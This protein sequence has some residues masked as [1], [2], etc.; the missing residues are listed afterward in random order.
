M[1]PAPILGYPQ[2]RESPLQSGDT[3]F[4]SYSSLERET[5][6]ETQEGLPGLQ[7][8]ASPIRRTN[9]SLNKNEGGIFLNP[10]FCG[11]E[12]PMEFSGMQVSDLHFPKSEYYYDFSAT[13]IDGI[14]DDLFTRQ[15][16]DNLA[17]E[18]TWPQ[19]YGSRISMP[20][21]VGHDFSSEHLFNSPQEFSNYEMDNLHIL[22]HAT[23]NPTAHQQLRTHNSSTME[24]LPS[25]DSP[26]AFERTPALPDT[27]AS[28]ISDDGDGDSGDGNLSVN[29]ERIS[30]EPYAKL[31]YRALLAAPNHS[32]VLQEIY[33]W[34]IDHTDKANSTSSGWRNSIRHNL[35][36]NAVSNFP[37][38]KLQM[39]ISFRRFE[40]QIEKPT[41]KRP[42]ELQNGC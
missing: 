30:D 38:E 34:F 35:S 6:M 21:R 5:S 3:N 26:F 27:L 40:R 13:N 1:K 23:D 10:I 8:D 16:D 19:A 25:N 31:I 42:S 36:M 17:Y 2:F 14:Q 39:L 24:D 12:S 9:I 29:G 33:Q 11:A 28:L 15:Q 32:M 18:Y 41:E 20:M 7:A 22:D 37:L 4:S